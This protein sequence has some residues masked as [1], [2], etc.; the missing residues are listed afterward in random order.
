ME[1]R[2]GN[3]CAFDSLADLHRLDAGDGHEMR[4]YQSIE[5]LVPLGVRPDACRQPR[6]HDL[7]FAADG[8]AAAL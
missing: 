6:K 8:V 4:G 7:E 5:A 1:L 2:A 3:L